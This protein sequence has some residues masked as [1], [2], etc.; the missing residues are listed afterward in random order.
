MSPVS[1]RAAE[2]DA[3]KPEVTLLRVDGTPSGIDQLVHL[4][5]ELH[6]VQGYDAF[7][8]IHEDAVRGEITREEYASRMLEQEFRALI[9]ARTFFR[10]HLRD[11]SQ[12]EKKEAR[13]YYRMLYGPDSFEEHVRQVSRRGF[14]LR[15][16]Y[17]TLYDSL[18]LSEREDRQ[19]MRKP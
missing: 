3:R 17:R 11:L 12:S 15:D 16:H 4:L 14:D 19:R 7:A 18:V 9:A 1:G 2:W 5:F 8:S 10:E 6:N 13:A